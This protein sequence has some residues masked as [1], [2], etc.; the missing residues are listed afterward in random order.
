MGLFSQSQIEQISSI[1]AK[2]NEAIQQSA[3]STR[4]INSEL[5]DI[6]SKV[7]EYFKDSDA[8]LIETPEQLHNYVDKCIENGIAGIDTETTGLDRVHDWIVGASLYTPGLP[9]CY[10]PMKHLVPIFETPYPNQLTYEQVQIEFQRLVDALVKLIFANAD[11]DLAMIFKDLKV[12]MIPAFYFDVISVWRCLKENELDN[13][14]KGLYAKYPMRGKVDPK[15]FSDFFP[16]KLFP[17]CKPQVAKLYAGNDAKITYQLFEWQLPYVTKSNPKCQK[18]HLEKIADLWWNIEV[19][20]VRA[21]ALL[22]RTGVYFDNSISSTLHDRYTSKLNKHVEELHA[23]VQDLID[24]SN[25]PNDRTRPFR[26]GKDFNPNSPVHVKYAITK[27]LGMEDVTS[28]D[29]EQLDAIQHPIGKAILA[30]RGDVKLLSTYVDKLPK[31][32]GPDGRVHASFRSMGANTGRMCL[33]EGTLIT[34]DSGFKPIEDIKIG[35]MVYCYSDKFDVML[36]PVLN[37]WK[38]GSMRECVKVHWHG[39]KTEG[40]LRCTPEH[41]IFVSGKG[42]VEAQE[43]EDGDMLLK[44]DKSI[45]SFVTVDLVATLLCRYDVYD[46][47][48]QDCHNFIANKICVHNSSESPNLQNIPSKAH[49]IRHMFRATPGSLTSKGYVVI[50]SDFSSQEPKLLA[51]ISGEPT[52]IQTFQEGRDIYATL[53]SVAYNLPYSQCLEFN[54]DTHE[55]QPEGK[56]RRGVGKVLNLGINYGMSV[57]SIA[58]MLFSSDETMSPEE[59]IKRAQEIYDAVM[60]GFPKLSDFIAGAQ[61]AAVKTGYTETI[62]GRRRHHP[63]MQLPEFEFKPMSGYMNPDIDPLDPTTLQNK[64]AIPQ[65]IINQ[66]TKEFKNY[67]YYGQIVKR[68]KALAEEKI[69][70]TNN[71]S[72]ITEASRQIVNSIVQGSAA[73]LTKMAIIKLINDPEWEKIGGR[74]LTP[75]HDELIVEVPYEFKDEG[76]EILSRCMC[77]AGDFLPFKLTCDCETSYRWYGLSIETLEAHDKPVDLNKD[78]LT[79][80]NIMWLQAMIVECEYLLPVYKNEDGSKPIGDAA[81]G[82]N[83]QWSQELEDAINDYKNRYSITDDV[84]FIEHIEMRVTRGILINE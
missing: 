3:Q 64:E 38:T 71:R 29:K 37:R 8:I 1:A 78:T 31:S 45:T 19:P 22:H 57:E 20:M 69:K 26:T 30:V 67:K 12:D 77:S 55:Y 21:C 66:L 5:Q 84:K 73:D 11:F 51:F 14:L 62:L 81:F 36:K 23:I 43:I 25:K 27:L 70:V 72:K 63:N 16:P 47:E 42:W 2:S 15:K 6:E 4:S 76:A 79:E 82:I 49:D 61:A 58:D 40:E 44:F 65:R 35:D 28:A 52:M 54:P 32:T 18:H 75:V 50:S 83:G 68:T 24:N 56:Q 13:T 17:Y 33:A 80:S 41:K 48:V 34:I 7:I 74:F 59:K 39:L 46:I 10:I 9:E 53:A 60:Q